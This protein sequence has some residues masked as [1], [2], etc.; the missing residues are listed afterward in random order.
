MQSYHLF[1]TPTTQIV[2]AFIYAVKVYS[3]RIKK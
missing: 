1:Q 3:E 2:L